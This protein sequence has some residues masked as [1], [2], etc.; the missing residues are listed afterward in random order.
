MDGN[1][2]NPLSQQAFADALARTLGADALSPLRARFAEQIF[3]DYRADEL[4]GLSAEDLARLAADLWRLGEARKGGPATI[5]LTPALGA[6]GRPLGL[7]LLAIVQEDASFLLDSTIG[8]LSASG[9][10]TR[11]LFHPVVEVRQDARPLSLILAVLA[12]VGEDRKA[13]LQVAMIATMADVRA[14]V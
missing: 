11:A 13:D 10:E 5:R 9:V 6:D 7:D 4:P 8:E 2:V 12:P 3:R 1:I 14:T